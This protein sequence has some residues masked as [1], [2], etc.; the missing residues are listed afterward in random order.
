MGIQSFYLSLSL[1]L[2]GAICVTLGRSLPWPYA[3]QIFF[4]VTSLQ[5]DDNARLIIYPMN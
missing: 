3:T 5:D 4:L 2:S 1:A